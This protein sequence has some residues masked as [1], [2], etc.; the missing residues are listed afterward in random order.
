MFIDIVISLDSG[1]IDFDS[2]ASESEQLN[3]QQGKHHLN[4]LL[5]HI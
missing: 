1:E 3:F 5:H 4:L 2:Y